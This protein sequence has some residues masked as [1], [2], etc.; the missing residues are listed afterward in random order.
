ML[1]QVF[2][3]AKEG[4]D[5]DRVCSLKDIDLHI[6][7]GQ[8]HGIIGMNGAGK[9]TLLK[10]LTGVLD[11]TEGS[12]EIKGTVSALLELGTG[13]HG[14]LTGRENIHVN[15]SI[16]GYS[17]EQIEEKIKYILEFSELEE[18]F[19]RPVKIYSSGMYVRLAFS[20][21]IAVDPQVL[22]IDEALAVGDVYFQQ[23][24]MKKI[25]EFKKKGTTILFVSHDIGA[26]K[27]LCES[28]TL[29][30][31]GEVVYSGEPLKGIDLYNDILAE[32]KSQALI[33]AKSKRAETSKYGGSYESGSMEMEITS[34]KIGKD[35]GE[36]ATA[37]VS[38]DHAVFRVTAKVNKP[39][40]VNPTC[41]ILIRDRLGYDIFG[42]NTSH[43]G[44]KVGE[45]AVGQTLEYKFRLRL[46][47]GPGDYTFT[48]AL[49]AD[50]NHT[51]G[52]YHWI[53]RAEIIKIL[54]T[55]DLAFVGVARLEPQC[56]VLVG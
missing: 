55:S 39:G 46:N 43:L 47:L 4:V 53:D 33:K 27:M 40:V 42:T 15:G 9:S 21:A 26:I 18:F 7:E 12:V 48:V 2:G 24:C 34:I 5:Y 35:S 41:G 17:K 52:N 6:E 20:F 13:F 10:I 37:F 22:I 19:D 30:S 44:S 11:P 36:D 45:L 29:L 56:E 23:K 3:L 8:V 54:P 51:D 32:H 16:L 49:H 28:V 14:E 31:R 38:G 1:K 25:R 50:E